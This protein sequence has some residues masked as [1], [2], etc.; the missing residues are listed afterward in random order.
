MRL[1][2]R[3]PS[4]FAV[5][6]TVAGMAFFI[7]LGVWQLNRASEKVQL[8]RRFATASSAPLQAFATVRGGV[9]D[10]HYPHIEAHGRFLADRDYVLDDQMHADRIGVQVYAPFHALHDDRLLLV[11]LGFVPREGG[12]QRVPQLPPLPAAPITLHGLYAPPPRAGLKLGGDALPAQSAWPKTSIYLDLHNIGKDLHASIYPRVLLLDPDP[13]TP[14]IRQWVP[15]TMPPSRHRGYAVQWFTFA[16]AA[17]AI[18]VIM[19]RQ[20]PTDVTDDDE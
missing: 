19:H 11:D 16:L 6:L 9:A 20:H 2:L 3:R 5:A 18:F 17:L 7:V 14:Y 15:A 8:L 12:D 1:R 10:E 13:A 4:W